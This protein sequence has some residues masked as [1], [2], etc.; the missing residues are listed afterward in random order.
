MTLE[1]PQSLV[2]ELQ[3]RDHAARCEERDRFHCFITQLW[4]WRKERG[5][6]TITAC[7]LAHSAT[8]TIDDHAKRL[9]PT[10]DIAHLAAPLPHSKLA[11]LR[12]NDC[13]ARTGPRW[14]IYLRW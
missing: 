6:N 10:T 13:N 12:G 3:W 2:I 9:R 5:Y 4:S 1:L 14:I 8:F 11:F 7:N